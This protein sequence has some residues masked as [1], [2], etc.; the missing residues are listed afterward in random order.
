MSAA[1]PISGI[2]GTNA[3]LETDGIWVDYGEHGRFLV[4]RAG[5]KNKAFRN[6]MEKRLRPYRA[7]MSMGTMDDS[8]V[9]RITRECFAEAVVLN[10]ELVDANGDAIE[11][12]REKC[13]D[14]FE[15]LPD[16]FIDIMQQAQMVV[17]FVEATRAEDAKDSGSSSTGE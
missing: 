2:F 8:V 11:F 7:A 5:G 10:W 15:E 14:L 4:A 1:K 13:V 6:L 9:E 12:T 17:N 16:L 3:S